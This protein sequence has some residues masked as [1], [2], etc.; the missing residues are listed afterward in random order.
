MKKTKSYLEDRIKGCLIGGA[1]GDALGF[2]IEFEKNI[3]NKEITKYIGFNGNGIFSDDTQMTLFT[4]NA[5]LYNKTN[6]ILENIKIPLEDSIFKAYQDWLD[7][8]NLYDRKEFGISWIKHI[9]ELRV[10]RAPGNTCL[11]SLSL[12]IEGNLENPINDSKGCG[13]VMRVAPIGLFFENASFAGEIAVKSTALTHGHPLGFMPS[14]ILACMISII[15]NK[16]ISLEDAFEETMNIFNNEFNQ[17]PDY[18]RNLADLIRKAHKL[19]KENMSDID[20]IKI[21]GE[22][23]VAEE[24]LAI[25]LYSCF[26]YSNNFIDA[27]IC[28]I[29]HDGDSDSTGA[30]AG[31]IMG[32]YLGFSKI[33]DYYVKNLQ[34]KDIIYEIS[35]DI[36]S[37][38][39]NKINFK[40][41]KYWLSKY[42]KCER[43]EKLKKK[44]FS[45]F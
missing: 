29:N 13:G 35:D 40:K 4:A 31:N 5:L 24:A 18:K 33:P 20:A 16:K 45:L 21:L 43:N 6:C 32:V 11:Q 15:L 25:A 22:G 30:I 8:Q 27:V 44:K 37:V 23:W 7:T 19:S 9:K 14:F 17:Y 38:I 2:P 34:L 42:Y 3:N 28:S 26:K 39:V 1:I 10:R 36:Y 41:D 12:K